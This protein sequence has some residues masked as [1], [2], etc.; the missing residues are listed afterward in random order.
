[1]LSTELCESLIIEECKKIATLLISKNRS[2]GNSVL[3]PLLVFSKASSE[4]RINIRIDDKLSRIA[5][6]DYSM[7][8]DT[9]LDLIGYLILKRVCAAQRV[10]EEYR[11]DREA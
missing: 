5:R 8:E 1:M 3:K 7:Q 10:L 11:P 4:E 9:E 2:Y 6:G